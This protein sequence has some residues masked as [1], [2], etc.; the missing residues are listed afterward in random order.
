MAEDRH[1]SRGGSFLPENLL[2]PVVYLALGA[3]GYGGVQIATA[4]RI[5][6]PVDETARLHIETLRAEQNR[7]RDTIQRI[8]DSQPPPSLIS[9]LDDHEVRIRELER[10]VR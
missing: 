7:L 4:E 6:P 2:W 3:G 8:N 5:G 9:R 1:G 10:A